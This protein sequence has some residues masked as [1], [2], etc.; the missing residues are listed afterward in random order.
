MQE[1]KIVTHLSPMRKEKVI[2]I[3]LQYHKAID[4]IVKAHGSQE[5][6]MINSTGKWALSNFKALFYEQLQWEEWY[7]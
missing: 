2:F 3:V 4:N 7:V 1:K 6:C 5:H